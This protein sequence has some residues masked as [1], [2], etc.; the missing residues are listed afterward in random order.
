MDA[1]TA[2]AGI[3]LTPYALIVIDASAAEGVQVITT[4]TTILARVT[5]AFV[6]VNC[7]KTF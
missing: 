4:V 2:D 7:K 6:Y 5:F 1:W 3:D